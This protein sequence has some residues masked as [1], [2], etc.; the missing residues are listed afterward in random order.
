[1]KPQTIGAFHAKTHLSALLERVDR[2]QVFVITRRGRAIAELRPVSAASG[3][4]FGMDAGRITL[5][6]DF[7]APLDDFRDY[8]G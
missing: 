6:D 1:M 7:D 8:T 3:L 5:S 4:R 2:G